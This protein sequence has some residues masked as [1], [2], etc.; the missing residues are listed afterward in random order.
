MW[1]SQITSCAPLTP[2]AKEHVLLLGHGWLASSFC[3]AGLPVAPVTVHLRLEDK[4]MHRS[5]VRMSTGLA[6]QHGRWQG[7]WVGRHL[8]L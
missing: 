1:S 2:P 8:K 6:S 7:R 4:C 3:N 5:S